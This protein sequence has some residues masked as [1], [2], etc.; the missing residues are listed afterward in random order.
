MTRA[1]YRMLILSLILLGGFIGVNSAL[2]ASPRAKVKVKYIIFTTWGKGERQFGAKRVKTEFDDILSPMGFG[3]DLQE[4]TL[5]IADTVN[6]RLC[7]Y[8]TDG[9]FL[10]NCGI[11]KFESGPWAV[12]V[13]EKYVFAVDVREK[14]E[15]KDI[16]HRH[17]PYLMRFDKSGKFQKEFPIPELAPQF[18]DVFA[19]GLL[20]FW[21]PGEKVFL[22]EF[23]FDAEG[24]KVGGTPPVLDPFDLLISPRLG[25]RYEY[26]YLF[27]GKPCDLP[28]PQGTNGILVTKLDLKGNLLSRFTLSPPTPTKK[29]FKP[30]LSVSGVDK[31]GCLITDFTQEP[32]KGPWKLRTTTISIHDPKT[33]RVFGSV[34]LEKA[35]FP[36]YPSEPF[37][38]Q[39]IVSLNGNV[40]ISAPDLKHFKIIKVEFQH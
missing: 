16:H 1:S 23:V 2:K 22:N 37:G 21:I 7:C 14:K 19:S 40:Y 33:G 8:T 4:K 29:G 32:L 9:K 25:W 34:C 12:A 30:T 18:E 36:I 13:G 20:F 10:F 15:E 6:H 24:H 28:S 35:G 5:W 27:N 26:T 38:W 17:I 31:H 3:I 11:G 39:E